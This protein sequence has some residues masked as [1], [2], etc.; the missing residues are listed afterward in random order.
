VGI[1]ALKG[2]FKLP[3]VLAEKINGKSYTVHSHFHFGG[4]A[5]YTD[6]LIQFMNNLYKDCAVPT[7]IVYTSK[8]FYACTQILD[9]SK[10]N[11]IIHSG[12]L[13]GNASLPQGTLLF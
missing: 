4:F 9:P 8:L 3:L 2:N 7:D 6:E 13:Q 5:K 11:L 10:K 1:S 12:G